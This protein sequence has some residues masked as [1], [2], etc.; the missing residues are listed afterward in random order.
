[1]QIIH[2]PAHNSFSVEQD[3]IIFKLTLFEDPYP[4]SFAKSLEIKLSADVGARDRHK[5]VR[6]FTEHIASYGPCEVT[7]T[8]L[9]ERVKAIAAAIESK[10]EEHGIRDKD[11]CDFKFDSPWYS[12]GDRSGGYPMTIEG[13]LD[14]LDISQNLNPGHEYRRRKAMDSVRNALLA[15]KELPS[16]TG[17]PEEFVDA[18]L[19]HIRGLEVAYDRQSKN[20]LQII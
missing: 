12:E 18:V 17:F 10:L 7:D 16:E 8:A 9:E 1:M 14:A 13:T 5:V 2:N 11:G 6:T 3:G 15:M 4:A 20:R 19:K